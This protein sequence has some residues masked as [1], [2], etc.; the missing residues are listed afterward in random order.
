M[1]TL[2]KSLLL[3]MLNWLDAQL[4]LFWVR[5]QIASEGN[6]L[7]AR[8]LEMG[9]LHFLS[10]KLAIGAFAAFLLYKCSHMPLARRG[11]HVVL[12]IYILLMFVHAATGYTALGWDAPATV[13]AYFAGLPKALLTF[14]F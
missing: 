14:L 9:D 10:V 13:F 6:H 8:L 11:M 2:S 7:M 5:Q 1:V 3:F 4:T 12:A